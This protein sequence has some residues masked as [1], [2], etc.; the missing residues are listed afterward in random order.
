MAKRLN[1]G[2]I[3]KQVFSKR[4]VLKEIYK[5]FGHLTLERYVKTWEIPNVKPDL[6]FLES[7]FEYAE[8]IYSKKIAKQLVSQLKTKPLVS[9]VDHLGVGGH[10]FFVN[11]GM[12][13]SLKF[14]SEELALVLA[15]ESV[16]LNNVTSWSGC[17]L[18]HDQAGSL[19][20]YSF[21]PDKEKI[22]PVFS[23]P[24]ISKDNLEKLKNK[25]PHLEKQAQEIF[26]KNILKRKSFSIQASEVSTNLWQKVF[27]NAPKMVYL[28]L[29]SIL[30][31]YLEK[32]LKDKRNIFSKIILEKQGQQL[33]NKYF[34]KDSTFMFWSINNKG[35]RAKLDTINFKEI[36][37]AI[38]K[39]T[40]YP[41]STLG[42]L[43]LLNAGVGA[44]GGFTQTTWLT[45]VKEKFLKIL[46]IMQVD[47]DLAEKIARVPTKNFS[48]SGLK[49][50]SL[51]DLLILNK[52]TYT[53]YL[54][55]TKSLTL[56]QSIDQSLPEI[57]KVIK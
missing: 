4:P 14:K 42:F 18:Q 33:W 57:Y 13:Y 16:S 22:L 51:W 31:K 34:S 46:K 56:K 26:S 2:K 47:Q 24:V 25:V 5:K 43:L 53:D 10:P 38:K 3:N 54:K 48:E 32:L 6:L 50:L 20:H 45:E 15:T 29:E 39:R 49:N 1:L 37:R 12:L 36:L 35:R 27:P 17:V 11:S 52:D 8:T 28:P 44:V 7:V 41:S 21:F 19:R 40:V 23:T 55:L 30:L 9:T